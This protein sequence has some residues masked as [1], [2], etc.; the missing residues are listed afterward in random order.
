MRRKDERDR[1]TSGKELSRVRS[2]NEVIVEG[3]EQV[4]RPET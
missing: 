4:D 2:A 3:Q 1:V